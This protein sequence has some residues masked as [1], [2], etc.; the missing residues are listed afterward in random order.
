MPEK[1]LT[2]AEALTSQ[3][4][5]LSTQELMSLSDDVLMSLRDFLSNKH[6]E[7]NWILRGRAIAKRKNHSEAE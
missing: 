3:L 5:T 1:N 7:I 2:T 4:S 6:S